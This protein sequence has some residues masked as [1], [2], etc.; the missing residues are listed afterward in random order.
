MAGFFHLGIRRDRQDRAATPRTSGDAKG[1][2]APAVGRAAKLLLAALA[3]L[4]AAFAPAAASAAEPTFT[5]DPVTT[6]SITTAHVSGKVT[7]DSEAN[8]GAEGYWYFQYCLDGSPG[9]CNAASQWNSGPGAFAHTLPAGTTDE[10]VEETLTGLRAA[11]EYT[12]RLAALPFSTFTEVFSDE[13]TYQSF[14]TDPATPPSLSL[15]APGSLALTSV[16]LSGAIDPEGGNTDTDAG[17]LPISWELQYAPLADP[18]NWQPAGSTSENPLT[19]AN[20]EAST[21]VA[22]K[23]LATG[24]TPNTAYRARLVAHYAGLTEALPEG[25]YEEFTTLAASNAPTLS[26]EPASALTRVKA[27]LAGT[28]NPNGGNVDPQ[29]GPIPI[30]WELQY[31]KASAPTAWQVA[32]TG[33]ISGAGAEGADSSAPIAVSANVTGLKSGTEYLYR[34][35]ATYGGEEKATAG[36]DS[37]ETLSSAGPGVTTEPAI[38]VASTTAYL[39]GTVNPNEEQTLY[40][41]EYGPGNCASTSCTAV[42]LTKE[43]VTEALVLAK[44]KAGNGTSPIAASTAVGGLEPSTTYHFRLLAENA[45]GTNASGDE[46]FTTAAVPPSDSCANDAQRSEQ[47]ATYLPECRAYEFA[48]PGADGIELTGDSQRFRASQVESPGLPQAAVFQ[49]LTGFG[50]VRG[51][52]VAVD[53]IAER[54]ARPGTSGWDTHSITPPQDALS[55][56]AITSGMDPLYVGDFSPD[57]TRGIFRAWSPL[58]ASPNVQGLPNFYRRDDVRSAGPGQYSLITPSANPQLPIFIPTQRPFLA[59]TSTDLE[60]VAFESVRNLTSDA[61]GSAFKLYKADGSSLRLVKPPASGCPGFGPPPVCSIGGA[62]SSGGGI[63]PVNWPHVISSDGSRVNFSSP[64]SNGNPSTQPGLATALFQLDDRGTATSADDAVI[65]VSASERT[66]SA[67]TGAA[68]YWTASA[69]GNRV[70]FSSEERLTDAP[71]GGLYLWERQPTDETQSLTI[72]AAGGTFTLTAHTQVTVGTGTLTNGSE[73]VTEVESGSF[74]VGQTVHAPGIPAGTTVAA[75]QSGLLTLSAPATADGV[76][77]LTASVDTTTPPLAFGASAAQVQ[78]ALEP[79]T[80]I[81]KGNLEVS[82]G[83][84]G[85]APYA[86]TFVGALAGVDVADL[87]AD[88]TG[89]TGSGQTATVDTTE[90]IQNLTLIESNNPTVDVIGASEDGSRLF[91]FIERSEIILWEAVAGT[92]EGITYSIGTGDPTDY[93]TNTLGRF[94]GSVIPTSYV[95]PDGSHL[96]FETSEGS[97]LAPGYLHGP[98]GKNANRGG[99]GCSEVYIY[100]ADTSTPLHPDVVCASCDS[101][102]P[103]APEDTTVR[104]RH[105]TGGSTSTYHRSRVAT[106][107]GAVFFDTTEALLARDTNGAAD[108]YEYDSSNGELGLI[109]SGTN[110]F[111]SYFLETTPDGRDAFFITRQRLVG[112]DTDENYD[113]YDARALGGFP[114]PLPKPAPCAGDSCRGAAASSPAGPVVG[115]TGGGPGNRKVCPRGKRLVRRHGRPVCVKKRHRPHRRHSKSPAHSDRRIGR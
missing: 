94:Y 65:Q 52:G 47:H 42:P 37:F 30:Q 33:T 44:R 48:S 55:F 29:D 8:G 38:H 10:P 106:D 115:S 76:E 1:S 79:L 59:G 63:S 88:S 69:D 86:I 82:G 7:F 108:V 64:G 105:F 67:P 32:D 39:K 6:A 40:W 22:V 112:W 49:T 2:G 74:S 114:E 62:G 97:G 58:D 109:S 100:N 28:L 53:S 36:T 113:L 14:T 13:S 81:G 110:P 19:G 84:G 78:A 41:F 54:T 107:Q 56:R 87:T 31:T 101:S 60:H 93:F 77:T 25:E 71:S 85:S 91:F 15:D 12:V 21:G 57:L 99:A 51:S 68:Q 89:L 26:V 18:E 3:L 11:T 90:P 46:T 83:P 34:L 66:V 27:H 111:G 61:G 80:G 103:K 20:A 104:E 50:D 73:E 43:E 23:A 75:V 95:T 70:F 9:E 96:I 5:V 35:R 102:S 4:L 92:P 16:Q 45:S 98:C 24:L 72:D 17:L